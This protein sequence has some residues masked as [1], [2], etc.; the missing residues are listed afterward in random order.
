MSE[1]SI[2][3]P[4]EIFDNIFDNLEND[5]A[6]LLALS[7]LRKSWSLPARRHLLQNVLLNGW[8][9][10]LNFFALTAAPECTFP[11]EIRAKKLTLANLTA[12]EGEGASVLRR[13]VSTIF[14]ETS[15]TIHTSTG[16]VTPIL[17]EVSNGWQTISHLALCGGTHEASTF[18]STLAS[19]THL[20]SL[21]VQDFQFAP[22][23]NA[24]AVENLRFPQTIT[25][26]S[27]ARSSSIWTFFR[28][29]DFPKTGFANV[30][31]LRIQDLFCFEKA[32]VWDMME[33]LKMAQGIPTITFE[34]FYDAKCRDL[35]RDMNNI[36]QP[37]R[38]TLMRIPGLKR[39]ELNFAAMPARFAFETLIMHTIFA[40]H[41]PDEVSVDVEIR[42]P[43]SFAL[44]DAS[45][46]E[47]QLEQML[48]ETSPPGTEEVTSSS[49]L[50]VRGFP[51]ALPNSVGDGGVARVC[52]FPV[53]FI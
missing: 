40:P 16:G 45:N 49:T 14:V 29:Y 12:T 17:T 20:E 18:F 34:P 6:T 28:S 7:N 36:F 32:G 39:L 19:L 27:L 1:S 11:K 52:G 21:E 33:C 42:L 15:L 30:R 22:I 53:S 47:E 24:L 10:I 13:L 38:L 43:Q 37:L 4:T 3:Y 26:L 9:G 2:D 46:P 25:Q 41:L 51:A 5:E 50:T 23:V 35:I 8:G 44:W 31:T 48:R